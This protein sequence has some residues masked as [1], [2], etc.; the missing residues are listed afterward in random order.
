MHG[1]YGGGRVS[2]SD[3]EANTGAVAR[4]SFSDEEG[5]DD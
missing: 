5:Y 2:W 4:K 1:K 3:D